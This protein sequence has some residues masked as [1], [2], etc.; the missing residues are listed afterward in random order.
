GFFMTSWSG[1]GFPRYFCPAA[2]LLLCFLAES[3]RTAYLPRWL[4]I[5][6][7]ALLLV[8]AFKN[9]PVLHD[10]YRS[11]ISIT[12]LPAISLT[13]VTT[14]YAKGYDQYVSAG[15]AAVTNGAYGYYFPDAS[16]AAQSMGTDQANRALE[17]WRAGEP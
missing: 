17:R 6:L 9:V 2:I 8:G 13:Q 7:V 15:Q 11:G 12:S 16:Y 5:T 1:D 14:Q 4:E 3:F 10:S